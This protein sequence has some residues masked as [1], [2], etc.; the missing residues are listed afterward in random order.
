MTATFPKPPPI[1]VE[2]DPIAVADLAAHAAQV[3]GVHGVPLLT[4]PDD[5][6]KGLLWS[7]GGWAKSA[8]PLVV[9]SAL[10][11]EVADRAAAVDAE[12]NARA[13]AIA[14]E[15][16]ARV[17][18]EELTTDAHGGIVAADDARLSDARL[19]L[20]HAPSHASGGSDPLTLADIARETVNTLDALAVIRPQTSE[21]GLL[22]KVPDANWGRE[23]LPDG[24]TTSPYGAQQA[25][26]ILKE[27]TPGDPN[28]PSD[29]MLWRVNGLGAMGM[30]GNM[31]VATGL[32]ARPGTW[33]GGPNSNA[34]WVDPSVDMT[35][36]CVD[37]AND[38]PASPW[39]L[40]RKG[41]S[42][43]VVAQI[44][45]TGQLKANR[46][47][48]ASSADATISPLT[49][50][51][52]ASPSTP[53]ISVRDSTDTE[54]AK[55]MFNGGITARP[56]MADEAFIG[57]IAGAGGLRLGTDAQLARTAPGVFTM[58]NPSTV[59]T[60]LV[61]QATASQGTNELFKAKSST[62]ADLM[63][64]DAS[65]NVTAR[66]G[67]VADQVYVGG[68]FGVAAL[69]F[70]SATDVRLFRS[71][72][73]AATFQSATADTKLIVKGVAGQIGN[74]VEVQDSTGA[75]KAAFDASG[76]VWTPNLRSQ[77]GGQRISFSTANVGAVVSGTSASMVPLVVQLAAGQTADAAQVQTSLGTVLAK[78]TAAGKLAIVAAGQGLQL[79]SPDGLTTRTLT[80]DNSGALALS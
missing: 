44:D 18:H 74:P 9:Q 11:A 70:G 66:P 24:V 21:S 54:V 51:H 42:G 34:I 62:G 19:P 55:V 15:S 12:A 79:T 29:R 33:T 75:I 5:D 20:A 2:A 23:L 47:V 26:E 49:V 14:A 35:G 65:G 76:N 78:V 58:V 39:Q 72:T 73:G 43:E 40:W 4:S 37:S 3:T 57:S 10:D 13:A 48:Y 45:S 36:I 56:G 59:P 41:T 46:S 80:L 61:V 25:I 63:K 53:P 31:H 52:A 67:G 77:T 64:V 32:N 69:M 38:T 50:K 71:A 1:V 7:N 68:Y 28:L 8:T 60:Q 17:A 16:A 27:D 6:G 22:I 30:A